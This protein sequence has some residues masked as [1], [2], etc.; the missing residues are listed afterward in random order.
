MLATCTNESSMPVNACRHLPTF[1]GHG[2]PDDGQASPVESRRMGQSEAEWAS[3]SICGTSVAASCR[4]WPTLLAGPSMLPVT[5][6][7]SSPEPTMRRTHAGEQW[8]GMKL[9]CSFPRRCRHSSWSWLESGCR[10]DPIW[11][12]EAWIGYGS[13]RSA[14]SATRRLPF[15]SAEIDVGRGGG[16]RPTDYENVRA[17]SLSRGDE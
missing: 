12:G 5:S 11:S 14:V 2:R 9:R 6:T 17:G 10:P 7:D 1:H 3:R 4:A 8:I 16:E 15:G 13:W